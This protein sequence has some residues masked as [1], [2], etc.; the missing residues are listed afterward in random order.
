MKKPRKLKKYLKKLNLNQLNRYA[1]KKSKKSNINRAWEWYKLEDKVDVMKT[2]I[3]LGRRARKEENIPV[4][5]V[6]L[7]I[8]IPILYEFKGNIRNL[9]NWFKDGGLYDSILSELNIRYIDFVDGD[10]FNYKY[11]LDFRKLAADDSSLVKPYTQLMKEGKHNEVPEQYLIKEYDGFKDFPSYYNNGIVLSLN[12]KTNPSIL[13][14]RHISK[15]IKEIKQ[16]RKDNIEDVTEIIKYKIDEELSSKE[17]NYI[18]K[19]TLSIIK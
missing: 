9:E 19:E 12:T 14:E 13:R 10:K 1:K 16:Y 4:R 18:Q 15:I 11:K 17:I 5:D 3:E 2:V 8:Y 7:C 6:C